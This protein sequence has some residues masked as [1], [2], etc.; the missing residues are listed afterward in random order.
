MPINTRQHAAVRE[1]RF[2]NPPVNALSVRSGL[3]QSRNTVSTEHV[4]A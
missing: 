2:S 1:I 4:G 3:C